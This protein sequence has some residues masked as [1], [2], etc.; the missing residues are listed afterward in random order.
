VPSQ[1]RASLSQLRLSVLSQLRLGQPIFGLPES[2][3]S[4][5]GRDVLAWPGFLWR[6][7]SG[8]LLSRRLHHRLRLSQLRVSLSELGVSQ[9]RLRVSLSV[10]SQLRLGEPIFGLPESACSLFG[11]DILA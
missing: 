1:L 4:L 6:A 2:A 9:L 11:C 7:S 5:F 8:H 3:C 10:L